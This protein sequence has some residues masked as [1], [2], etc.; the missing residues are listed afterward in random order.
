MEDLMHGDTHTHTHTHTQK[1]EDLMHG[2]EAA[3]EEAAANLAEMVA[4]A[5]QEVCVCVCVCM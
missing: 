1:M 2:D 3:I 4:H 5:G